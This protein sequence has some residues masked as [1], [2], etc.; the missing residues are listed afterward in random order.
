MQLANLGKDND[1]KMSP[2]IHAALIDSLFQTASTMLAGSLRKAFAAL[3]TALKTSNVW[4][5]PCVAFI[6]VAGSARAID[7]RMYQHRQANMTAGEVTKWEMR[8][9]LGAMFYA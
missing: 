9:Q 4:R 8:Y 3:M 2:S 7:V 1:Q 6:V 5:G